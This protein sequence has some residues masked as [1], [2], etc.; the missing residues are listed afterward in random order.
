MEDLKKLIYKS[1]LNTCELCQ[2]KPQKEFAVKTQVKTSVP[3]VL[4]GN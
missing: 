2:Y 4:P 1:N 3:T